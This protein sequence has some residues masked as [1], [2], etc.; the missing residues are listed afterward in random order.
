MQITVDLPNNISQSAD[1]AR[2]ALAALAIAGYR[3][4]KLTSAE[5][6]SLLG[7]SSRFQFDEF[8]KWHAVHDQDYDVDELRK[9]LNTLKTLGLRTRT[10]Q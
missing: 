2:E 8:L 6:R 9:D 10:S 4:G 3:T 7:F 1:P 5:A